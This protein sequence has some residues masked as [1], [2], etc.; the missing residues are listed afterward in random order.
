MLQLT[1]TSTAAIPVEAECIAPNTL[2]G[3]TAEEIAL[4]PVQHGNAPAPL[5]EFFRI[6][7]DAGDQQI[8]IKGDCSRVKLVGT[9]MTSGSITIEGNIGMHLGAEMPGGSIDVK[10]SAA[11]GQARRCV[12][13]RSAS[14]EM[15]GTLSVPGIAAAA[16]ACAVGSS[17]AT[18]ARPGRRDRGRHRAGL[19]DRLSLQRQPGPGIPASQPRRVLRPGDARTRSEVDAC[20]LLGSEGVSWFSAQAVAAL[21]TIP[22]IALDYPTVETLLR[23]PQSASRP[24]S[25]GFTCQARPTAWTRF[26]SR[27]DRSCRRATPAT[28]T[29]CTTSCGGWKADEMQATA[30][31]AAGWRLQSSLLSSKGVAP[32]RT[33][34]QSALAMDETFIL[35]PGRTS[36]QGTTLNEGKLTAD[37]IDETN[38]LFMCP[39]DM[40][41][42]GLV[43]GQRVR[44]RSGHGTV[45]LPCMAA[46]EGEVPAGL[47]FLP[48]GDLPAG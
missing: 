42:L 5:G 35:I 47:L 32:G 29:C 38:T 46:K 15:R 36:R 25:T 27:C 45:E 39:D 1:Y 43:D 30:F 14:A 20:L 21:Q 22:T 40:K 34:R 26:L 17:S 2:A 3:K 4:L 23:H 12:T 37:Y 11:T 16:S 18:Y 13:A 31:P 28:P 48:Y 24:Q 41:R 7:V 9:G 33:E 6:E 19:A 8:V 10:A 44:V